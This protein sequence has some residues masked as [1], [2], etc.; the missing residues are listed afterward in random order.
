VVRDSVRQHVRLYAMPSYQQGWLI[1]TFSSGMVNGIAV[2][3]FFNILPQWYNVKKVL[4]PKQKNYFNSTNAPG[5]M[6]LSLK[7]RLMKQSRD[8]NSAHGLVKSVLI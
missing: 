7:L 2:Q 5:S 4:L 6:H 3:P 8:G 1:Y